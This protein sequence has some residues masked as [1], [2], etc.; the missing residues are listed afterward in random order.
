MSRA[1]RLKSLPNCPTAKS[2][3]RLVRGLGFQLFVWWVGLTNVELIYL[4]HASW[5]AFSLRS[6]LLQHNAC[7][8]FIVISCIL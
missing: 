5:F 6:P 7:D 4:S 3:R 8:V 2:A 1:P